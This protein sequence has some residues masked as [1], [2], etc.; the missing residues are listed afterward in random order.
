MR[1]KRLAAVFIII[2]TALAAL[3]SCGEGSA[4]PSGKLDDRSGELAG[5]E[6]G[7]SS[8]GGSD[9][10]YSGYDLVILRYYGASPTDEVA[11][12]EVSKRIK[13]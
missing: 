8:D 4:E 12:A 3:T 9:Y 6:N 10:D 1:L 5:A 7:K 2:F 11:A 13:E